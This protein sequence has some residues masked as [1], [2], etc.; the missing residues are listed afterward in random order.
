MDTTYK[1]ASTALDRAGVRYVL[2]GGFA[3]NAHGYERGTRDVD[4]LIADADRA[5]ADRAMEDA[6]FL[7]FH[8]AGM[9]SRFQPP[10]GMRLVVD[11]LPL[12]AGTFEKL[13]SAAEVKPFSGRPTRVLC[14]RHLLAMK[15]HA[16]K[17]DS[18]ARGLKDLLDVV[19]LAR[20]N[21]LGADSD[22]LRELCGEFGTAGILSSLQKTLAGP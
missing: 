20:V 8:R 3:V 16:L 1:I 17:N 21:G 11:L 4:L 14:L 22:L 13:W 9:V 5:Q 7:C 6:G 12:D 2:A 18:P 19:E 10:A 15:I